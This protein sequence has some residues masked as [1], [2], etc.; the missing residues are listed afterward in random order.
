MKYRP[1][2]WILL[3]LGLKEMK[4]EKKHENVNDHVHSDWKVNAT[5]KI[6]GKRNGLSTCLYRSAK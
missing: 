4:E 1:L 2:K 6:Y 5:N 3:I